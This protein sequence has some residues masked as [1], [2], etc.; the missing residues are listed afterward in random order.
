MGLILGLDGASSP[1]SSSS[2]LLADPPPPPRIE[3]LRC[4][5]GHT[6]SVA[7]GDYRKDLEHFWHGSELLKIHILFSLV[8]SFGTLVWQS[9]WICFIFAFNIL[10]K[11]IHNFV[12]EGCVGCSRRD[13]EFT[14]SERM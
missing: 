14:F 3:I 6:S 9:F 1:S 4:E 13:K 2:P 8:D 11:V 5:Q 10:G 7:R 12:Q